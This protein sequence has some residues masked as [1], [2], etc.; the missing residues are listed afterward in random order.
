MKGIKK[1]VCK[2]LLSLTMGFAMVLTII[3]TTVF[4]ATY[5]EPDIAVNFVDSDTIE[6]FAERSTTVK[7]VF[8]KSYKNIYTTD[9][10]FGGTSFDERGV[11]YVI[12]TFSPTLPDL[13]TQKARIALSP[14]NTETN[15]INLNIKVIKFKTDKEKVDEAKPLA[16][17]A[18]AAIIATNSTTAGNILDAV[19]TAISPVDGVTA[20]WKS[21]PTVTLATKDNAGSITG[22]I[23]LTC[24]S[25][26]VEVEVNK[27]IAQL[28]I[29]DKDKVDEAKSLA[30]SA[31]TAIIATNSTT[32]GNI[33]DAVTTAIS[34]V[35]GV[36]AS[37]KSAPTV[38][39]AT[40][41]NAGSITGTIVLTSGSETVE[42]TV[43]KLIEKLPA[44]TPDRPTITVGNSGSNHQINN[45]KDMTFTCSGKLEDL[46]GV[47]VD[48]KLVDE[49]N[50]TLLSGSTILTLKASYLD[51][52]STGK[53]TLKFQY[54][55]NV[56]AE[57]DFT[58]IAKSG[59]TPPKPSSPQTGD[60]SNTM[61]YFGLIILSGCIA[62]FGFKKKK[63]L[64]K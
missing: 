43:N 16:E 31:I 48:G 10:P 34:P 17:S 57:T 52:L 54:K 6:I 61:L 32:A 36:T 35:D 42:V 21:A 59:V 25:E 47:Y 8:D 18:I 40:K 45:G 49:S 50:Y 15:F 55:D 23:V 20:S 58:I 30:Q 62:G 2:I 14:S 44:P 24:G 56:S 46:T 4:A 41:D 38:T 37:W 5:P 13:G 9:L 11:D 33:L 51:T 12:I 27:T 22:T 29:T 7:V 39:L 28:P 3:P 60:T 64:I 53:H 19:T 63:I 26:T 1:K